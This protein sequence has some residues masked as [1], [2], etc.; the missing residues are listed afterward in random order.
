MTQT[1][2]ILLAVA[3]SC[4]FLWR[5]VWQGRVD[6]LSLAFASTCIYFAPGF[7]GSVHVGGYSAPIDPI[8]YVAMAI[9]VTSLTVVAAAADK[10]ALGPPLDADF[11]RMIAPA[12]LLAAIA[13]MAVSLVTIGSGYVCADKVEMLKHIDLWYY[14]AAYAVP[15][16][17]VAALA[18]RQWAIVFA[19]S[20]LLVLD[21][22]IGFR[23]STA[24]T[25]LGAATLYGQG[26][27]KGW[28]RAA[29][30]AAVVL[31]IGVGLLLVKQAAYTIKYAMASQ[32]YLEVPE[33]TAPETGD[34][35]APD[36]TAPRISQV[37]AQEQLF[38]FGGQLRRPDVY[39]AAVT[40]SEPFVTQS[41]LNETVRQDF[42][43]NDG[44]LVRQLLSGVPGGA[45]IFGMHLGDVPTFTSMFQAELFPDVDFDMASNP[46]AQAYAAGGLAMVLVFALGYSMS[47]A[48][49]SLAFWKTS[50]PCRGCIATL[51][52]WLAFYFHRN[53]L[54]I[55]IG[56][57]K[58][59]A[60]ILAVACFVTWSIYRLRR[61]RKLDHV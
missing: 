27:L 35:R 38:H 59:T 46:W 52:A 61:K 39:V 21:L 33:S 22:A 2:F 25:F 57:M 24:I 19:C 8:A 10:V 1:T 28:R 6:P 45:T 13:S 20:V 36:P 42:R 53:D 47:V 58:Q 55:Q 49:L 37:S 11:G 34:L 15:F 41:I 16:S 7:Y 9:V 14:Y 40:Q 54:L 43:T 32:C 18:C 17:F 12:L 48:G 60:Y 30:F 3:C 29:T 50:G 5:T 26:A 56:I 23:A 44:Y 4:F 51:A 31:V